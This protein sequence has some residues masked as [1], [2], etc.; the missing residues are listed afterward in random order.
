MIA[1]GAGSI[2]CS[3]FGCIP[4][5]ASFSRSSVLSASG[6]KT[7][8]AS[9]FNGIAIFLSFCNKRYCTTLRW[10]NSILGCVV[11][12]ALAFLMPTFYFIPKSILG[13]VL[14]T[15]VYPMI[16]YHEIP[17]M[18]R[19]RRKTF[20][21]SNILQSLI[22]CIR[23]WLKVLSCFHFSQHF[24]AVCWLTWNT[25]SSSALKRTCSC[26]PTKAVAPNPP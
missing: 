10:F 5:T 22:F 21:S 8:F 25:V 18:W 16:E 20:N 14:I 26:L 13:A 1:V 24:H 17:S 19:G 15:A 12:F 23:S 9:L 3:F 2:F 7:Q 11:L 6:G 4:L